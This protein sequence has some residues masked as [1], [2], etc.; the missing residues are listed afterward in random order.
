MTSGLREEIFTEQLPS[1]REKDR[2]LESIGRQDLVDSCDYMIY[3]KLLIMYTE[4]RRDRTGSLKR[5]MK[6]LDEELQKMRTDLER[7]SASHA[8]DPHQIMRM[9]LFLK[10]PFLFNRF[11]DFNESVILPLRM[12]GRGGKK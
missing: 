11:T 8:A 12:K 3:K 4:A 7:I 6:P 9:K 5:F 2:F 10:S 1:Y